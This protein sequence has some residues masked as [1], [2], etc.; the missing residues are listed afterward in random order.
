M[1]K[2]QLVAERLKH[3]Q[4][5]CVPEVFKCTSIEYVFDP[6]FGDRG[7][8]ET[9]EASLVGLLFL[10]TINFAKLEYSL[11]FCNSPF[12]KKAVEKKRQISATSGVLSA[13]CVAAEANQA[14]HT[15]SFVF[16]PDAED[17][18]G[19]TEVLPEHLHTPTSL[20]QHVFATKQKLIFKV[21]FPANPTL[22][23]HA[24]FADFRRFVPRIRLS[25]I[26][27]PRSKPAASPAAPRKRPAPPSDDLERTLAQLR[28]LRERKPEA[29]LSRS[30]AW[31]AIEKFLETPQGK[32][33]G[34]VPL[35][36]DAAWEL[37]KS[38]ADSTDAGGGVAR[39][40]A[41][42]RLQQADDPMAGDLAEY[43]H[44][45][46]KREEIR[47]MVSR[48]RGVPKG[49]FCAFVC[50]YYGLGAAGWL[51]DCGREIEAQVA[52]LLGCAAS[53]IAAVRSGARPGVL[54]AGAVKRQIKELMRTEEVPTAEDSV[55]ADLDL[56]I[57]QIVALLKTLG[58]GMHNERCPEIFIALAK[59]LLRCCSDPSLVPLATNS[60]VFQLL[61]DPC[62]GSDDAVVKV[63]VDLQKRV[64]ASYADPA[65]RVFSQTGVWLPPP[66]LMKAVLDARK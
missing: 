35:S 8:L 51:L 15:L 24:S 19:K 65:N 32:L 52:D 13:Y 41:H 45:L 12:Y 53:G 39:E 44:D 64:L 34:V 1:E 9:I 22:M 55:D 23:N 58:R 46:R 29:D 2:E 5:Q 54:D 7:G 57:L 36:G 14:F 61:A 27:A 25:K 47:S 42:V 16:A 10:F 37:L 30:T 40:L 3:I 60:L 18:L 11:G 17:A 33:L 38:I 21:K 66:D 50:F 31:G 59:R 28:K 48:Y 43:A 56:A 6:D 20:V 26:L 49:H 63:K 62:E 4:E